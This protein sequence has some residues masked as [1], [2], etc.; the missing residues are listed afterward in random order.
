ME[1]KLSELLLSH[2]T[3]L[4][5]VFDRRG[6]VLEASPSTRYYSGNGSLIGE[7]RA[8]WHLVHPEDRDRIR[9]RIGTLLDNRS[10]GGA[11]TIHLEFRLIVGP[12]ER[13]IDG[14][15]TRLTDP[16]DGFIFSGRDTT[17]QREVE[18]SLR[19]SGQ[20]FT[21]IFSRVSDGIA[22][23]SAQGKLRMFTGLL[24]KSLGYEVRQEDDINLR[25]IIIPEDYV[26]LETVAYEIGH[27][28][29]AQRH[30][31]FRIIARDGEVRHVEGT[32]TN[33]LEHPDVRAFV[34]NM[35]DTTETV[36][37]LEQVKK[38]NEELAER[39]Y[40]LET[41]RRV[42]L[43]LRDSGEVGFFVGGYVA[44]LCA[45]LHADGI[46][47]HL[48][49]QRGEFETIVGHGFPR[50]ISL[51]N[52]F[53]AGD[54]LAGKAVSLRQLMMVEDL[55]CVDEAGVALP[56]VEQAPYRGYVAA[57]LV[58]QDTIHGVVELFFHEQLEREPAW[59]TLAESLFSHGASA[60]ANWRLLTSLEDSN[61]E[62]TEAYDRTIE[63]WA[64]ALD[65]R[66]EETVGHSKRVTE[67][68]VRLA[69]QLGVPEAEII[70]IQRGALLHDIGK[71]GVPDNILLKPGKLTDA[72][73]AQMKKHP[74]Y[75]R[76]M[77]YPI[78]FLRP[79]LDIPYSHHER[80]DGAGYPEGLAGYDIPLAARIFSVVDV[81]DALIS[82]RPYR[83]AWDESEALRHIWEQ[84]GRHFDPEVVDAFLQ[85]FD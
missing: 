76:E 22:L 85:M 41:V 2:V 48:A 17:E 52:T 16:V 82:D 57:P 60:L 49:T 68:T 47:L 50:S 64:Y 1:H 66:D 28:P 45:A 43:T 59:L 80:W 63:G 71:M 56:A 26:R 79:A 40:H 30:V 46:A 42:Q 51:G 11:A 78:E 6:V 65:L 53:K 44:E 20:Y 18:R 67:M 5:V 81:Y 54:G 55:G 77:L 9:T 58:Y 14:Y 15:V 33:L 69:R 37:A 31:Q 38:L 83:E 36:V 84:R 62:L 19:A 73:F 75:A 10:A 25:E 39:V 27:T 61:S 4:L 21:A 35:H 70:H 12:E 3:D 29:N 8:L 32:V 72:E 13:L 74:E 24:G 23:V 7:R 34:Y